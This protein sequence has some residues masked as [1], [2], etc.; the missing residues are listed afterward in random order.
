MQTEQQTSEN[1][2]MQKKRG[3]KHETVNEVKGKCVPEYIIVAATKRLIR[4]WS[5]NY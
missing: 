4:K 2:L 3:K 1:I 5:T